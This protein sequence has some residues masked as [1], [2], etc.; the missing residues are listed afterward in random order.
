[1]SLK[2][3]QLLRLTSKIDLLN[4]RAMA[5]YPQCV[6]GRH[7]YIVREGY[8]RCS[9]YVRRNVTYGGTFSDA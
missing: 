2:R 7:I 6:K 1:M 8:A 5:P 9:S 4:I 3:E